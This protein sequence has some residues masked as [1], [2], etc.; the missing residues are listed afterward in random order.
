M[1]V[2]NN[3]RYL[4]DP[5]VVIESE[6]GVNVTIY[7]RPNAQVS[8][9][10]RTYLSIAG[11]TFPIIAQRLYSDPE[12]WYRIADVN[13]HVFY[14]GVITPGTVLRIPMAS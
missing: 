7:H 11:D 9:R 5:Q 8:F 14:P 2:Y 1:T 4:G 12:Q 10:Y 6:V 13:P 3:S